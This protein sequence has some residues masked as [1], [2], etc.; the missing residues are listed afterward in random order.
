M[1]RQ[2]GMKHENRDGFACEVS[3]HEERSV[4]TRL[5]G[6]AVLEGTRYIE[7]GDTC[8]RQELRGLVVV[9]CCSCKRI[10]GICE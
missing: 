10:Q 9:V 8:E 4:R 6:S 1:I 7:A 5:V 2:H 3:R